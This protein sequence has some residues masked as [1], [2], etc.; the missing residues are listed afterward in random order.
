MKHTILVPTNSF[1]LVGTKLRESM[2]RVI[3]AV[4][5]IIQ[6]NISSAESGGVSF[7]GVLAIGGTVK[8]RVC[9]DFGWKRG[10]K[11]I[12]VGLVGTVG[13]VVTFVV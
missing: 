10:E 6:R 3:E 8:R 12:E 13:G 1:L 2:C 7:V 11:G 9:V 5:A 4:A